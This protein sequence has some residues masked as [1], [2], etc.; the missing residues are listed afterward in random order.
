MRIGQAIDIH[1][2]VE[3]RDLILGGVK[4]EYEKGLL[5][6]SD[7]DVLLHAVAEA[8]IGALG[9]GDLGTHFPDTDDKYKDISSMVLLAEVEKLMS[10]HNYKIGNIDST[11]LIEAPKLAEYKQQ[12]EQN[13]ADVLKCDV[14]QV[15][16][17]ATR[18]E[19]L[20][21]VGKKKGVVA[22]AS[23]L[24]IEKRKVEYVHL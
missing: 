19:K 4:I 14:S 24:L 13:I 11:I 20:G 16:V 18:G 7:A 8:I 1:Q 12:M 3:N 23:V 15:N 2:L 21:F 6:H 22:L 10:S 9:L 5:G 17:K